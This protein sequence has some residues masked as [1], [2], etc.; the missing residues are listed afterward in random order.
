MINTVNYFILT[1]LICI[2]FL[3]GTLIYANGP[4]SEMGNNAV[5][6]Y[7]LILSDSTIYLVTDENLISDLGEQIDSL[8][9][10][11]GE[12][13]FDKYREI[14]QYQLV[15]EV[16]LNIDSVDFDL[17]GHN[18]R[19]K[20]FKIFN[21][22][23]G[24]SIEDWTSVNPRFPGCEL[25]NGTQKDKD[26]CAK[27]KMLEFIYKNIQYP[28]EARKSK[29][30]G[31]CVISFTVQKNGNLSDIIISKDIGG[32]CGEE[33]LRLINLMNEMEVSWIPG[34]FEG[35]LKEAQ[36]NVPVRFRLAE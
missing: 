27:Q 14:H 17:L 23:S 28:E 2:L 21:I 24:S 36:L 33:S 13:K 26:N 18:E 5:T 19:I 31:M 6:G 11:E 20:K 10:V 29:I 3:P 4:K 35:N 15:I 12:E 7:V 22:S 32:G 1:L 25:M 34:Y 30:Q 8:K 16:H 9:F